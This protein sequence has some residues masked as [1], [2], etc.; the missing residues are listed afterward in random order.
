VPAPAWNH[1]RSWKLAS[2]NGQGV[3]EYDAVP[4]GDH[5][6]FILVSGDL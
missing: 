4:D 1:G 5:R 6:N 3:T 2:Y